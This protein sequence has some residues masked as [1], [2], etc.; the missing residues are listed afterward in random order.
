MLGFTSV[1][2]ILM[3]LWYVLLYLFMSLKLSIYPV[4]EIVVL[5]L[6]TLFFKVLKIL[7]E[8]TDFS[9]LC[10]EH[11]YIA[12]FSSHDFINLL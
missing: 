9:L 2:V 11:I 7:S 4:Y 1:G 12:F 3:V 10:I 6:S 5:Y 8:I